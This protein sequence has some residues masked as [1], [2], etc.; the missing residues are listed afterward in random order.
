MSHREPHR[1]R[2][3]FDWLFASDVPEYDRDRYTHLSERKS[4]RGI[5]ARSG[6]ELA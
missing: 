3:F 2:G 4:G 1:E 6:P 5:G